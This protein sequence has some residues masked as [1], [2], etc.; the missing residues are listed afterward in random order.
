MD[1]FEHA[2]QEQAGREAPLAHRMRPR[3]FDDFAGQAHIVGEGKMLRRMVEAD[4]LTSIILWGPPGV[5]KTALANVIA[6]STQSHFER[7]NAVLTGVKDLREIISAT[8]ERRAL[9]GTRTLLFIDEIHRWNKAQQDALL[10]FVEEGTVILIGATTENPTFEIIRP[11]LSRSTVFEFHPLTQ[12]D[13]KSIILRALADKTRGFGN[14]DVQLDDDA[15]DHLTRI[16]GGDAR[17]ALNALELAVKTTPDDDTGKVHITIGVAEESIQKRLVRYDK[18]G[19]EHYDTISAFIKSVRGSDPDAAMLWLAKMIHAGEDPKFIM[20]RLLILAGEDIGMADPNGVV[21]ASACANTLEW[22]GMPEGMY[23]LTLATL[24]LATAPKSNS[25]TQLYS[26][27]DAIKA[28]ISTEVPGHL[29]SSPRDR[30][31]DDPRY[32]Y[33]HDFPNHYTAQQHLPDGV[34]ERFYHPGTIG[35]EAEAAE[36]L[37][38]IKGETPQSDE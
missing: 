19:D 18:G 24:Y 38:R 6:E 3:S 33:P 2:R 8:Q 27:L 7:M 14:L 11:L 12:A 15:L 28:G 26:A 32:V 25:A 10:P 21:V 4:Q 34:A 17:S 37:A 23:P 13:L 5:G 29:R 16:A 22:I 30:S 36:W 9:Y 20:R 35:F 31:Q 1:L